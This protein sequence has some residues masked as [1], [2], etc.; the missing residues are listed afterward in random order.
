M[1]QARNRRPLA[2]VLV[3]FILSMVPSMLGLLEGC[4]ADTGGLR[5]V[6]LEIDCDGRVIE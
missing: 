2:L 1:N 5:G 6:A 3:V 4:T